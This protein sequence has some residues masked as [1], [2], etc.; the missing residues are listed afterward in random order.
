L[1]AF[2]NALKALIILLVFV[3]S[4]CLTFQQI[5]QKT[6]LESALKDY[7]QNLRWKDYYAAAA[8]MAED[9]RD[10][11]L[12]D[13]TANEALNITD[14]TLLNFEP[15]TNPNEYQTLIRMEYYML[16][17]NT[18]QKKEIHQTWVLILDP[19]SMKP[20]GWQIATPFPDFP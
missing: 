9:N 1:K 18:I 13:F 5:D 20:K 12:A 8:Y 11:F 3:C 17:S 10:A 15:T 6:K 7:M 14:L 19:S 4:G 16:P 2:G